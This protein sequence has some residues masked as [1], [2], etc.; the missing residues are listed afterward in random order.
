METGSHRLRFVRRVSKFSLRKNVLGE[1]QE[2]CGTI[3]LLDFKN[4]SKE[5][6][7]WVLKPW[8]CPVSPLPCVW[9]DWSSSNWVPYLTRDSCGY[10]SCLLPRKSL[11]RSL[12]ASCILFPPSE[13]LSLTLKQCFVVLG[14]WSIV[15]KFLS[16]WSCFSPFLPSIFLP[17]SLIHE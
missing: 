14:Q 10:E 5:K 13:F 8:R 6:M 7:L 3:L 4:S 2:E 17:F 16:L 1:G 12:I 11:G 15:V 9:N